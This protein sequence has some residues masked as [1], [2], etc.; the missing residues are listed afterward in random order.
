MARHKAEESRNWAF[1]LWES[2]TVPNWK[3]VLSDQEHLIW[4][5]SPLHDKD[6][7]PDGTR[8]PNHIHLV[9]MFEGNKSL[10]QMQTLANK[11]YGPP[12]DYLQ[13]LIDKGIEPKGQKPLPVNTLR[14]MIR[15][16]IH[17]DDK[18]KYQYK[19][20]DIVTHGCEVNQYFGWSQTDIEKAS[21]EMKQ[22]I[23]EN[24]I[25]EFNE[26]VYVCLN[27]PLWDDVLTNKKT[28]FFKTW[29]YNRS[30]LKRQGKE[31]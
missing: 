24:N 15:Y 13:Q 17:L 5:C 6:I 4:C 9:V 23:I 31:L 28:Q 19:K 30:M 14:G 26:M 7:Y 3:E 27:N 11:L 20:E 8:K 16:F 2:V 21:T 29:L 22:Y 18:E 25:V 12:D 1:I 10:E